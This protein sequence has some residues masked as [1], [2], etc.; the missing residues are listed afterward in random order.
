MPDGWNCGL[1]G[2]GKVNRDACAGLRSFAKALL[3]LCG[4]ST[5][6]PATAQLTTAPVHFGLNGKT[7]IRAIEVAWP[8]RSKEQWEASPQIGNEPGARHG[9]S[10]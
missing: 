2:K 8:G 5:R 9:H 4:E 3:I 10:R 6:T 7:A 1:E